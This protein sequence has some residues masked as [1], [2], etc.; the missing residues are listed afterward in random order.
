MV[1]ISGAVSDFIAEG[2]VGRLGTADPGGQPLVVPICYAY[3]GE[4][5]YSA[6][7]GKPKGAGAGLRRIRNIQ[8]NARVSLCIDHYDED[9]RRLR[10][11]IIDG[12]ADLLTAGADFARAADLLATKYPQYRDV[13]LPRERGLMIRVRPT[14]ISHWRFAA[15]GREEGVR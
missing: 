4:V 6:I 3:D 9:W 11:V 2:R 7:D 13:P 14:R 5:L 12:E 10:W 8:G 1:A 15:A